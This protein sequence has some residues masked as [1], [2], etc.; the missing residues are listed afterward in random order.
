M[1]VSCLN[2]YQ[3]EWKKKKFYKRVNN[4]ARS[5]RPQLTCS[6]S[7]FFLLLF[8]KVTFTTLLSFNARWNIIRW[9]HSR[10]NILWDSR[11]KMT[12][13][14]VKF[15]NRS[16]LINMQSKLAIIALWGPRNSWRCNRSDGKS[17]ETREK[18]SWQ[19][20]KNRNHTIHYNYYIKNNYHPKFHNPHF[21][22]LLNNCVLPQ[23]DIANVILI[24]IL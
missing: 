22:A 2:F 16:N 8:F 9:G 21:I 17:G 3:V 12:N 5:A 1:W 24:L 14:T 7:F 15:G 19:F 13:F 23:I 10:D 20:K 6:I 11:K 4:Y 18:I